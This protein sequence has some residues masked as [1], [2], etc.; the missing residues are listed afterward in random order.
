MNYFPSIKIGFSL[1]GL[2]LIL[3][4]NGCAPVFSEMQSARTVGK[5]NV[6]ATASFSSVGFTNEN[7]SDHAQNHIGFQGAYGIT[8]NVD[9]RIRYSLAWLDDDI[10]DGS[11]NVF[12]FG[13]KVSIIKDRLSGYLP[14]GFAFG[15]DVGSDTWQFHP[16]LLGTVPVTD[17][18]DFNPSFKLLIPFVEDSENLIAFNL[19]LG[20][21]LN[22]ELTLRPEYGM[23]FNPGEDG[24]FKQFSI[25][26]TF[27]PSRITTEK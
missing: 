18:L 21:K 14:L 17:K 20:I 15:E 8:D 3:L 7:E 25:G 22:E 13:P 5:N 12:A 11:V 1:A 23:L 4:A 16:T 26:V 19:G 24:H 27:S 9:F 10:G 2:F 6:D